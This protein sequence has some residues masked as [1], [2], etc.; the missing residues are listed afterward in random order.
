MARGVVCLMMGMP[1]VQQHSKSKQ[2]HLNVRLMVLQNLIHLHII[3]DQQEPHPTLH[4]TY[5][6]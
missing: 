5:I 2:T 3:A 4:I 1:F 6:A